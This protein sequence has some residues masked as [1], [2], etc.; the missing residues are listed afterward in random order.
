MN[1]HPTIGRAHREVTLDVVVLGG[2]IAGLWLLAHLRARGYS[3]LLCE[4]EALGRGQTIAA[5]G[6]IHGGT[7]YAIG[8][9]LSKASHELAAM[10]S[11]WLRCLDGDDQPDLS[12]ARVLSPHHYLFTDQRLGTRF[13]AFLASKSLR[14]R[15]TP[16]AEDERPELLA[17]A[18]S[19][20]RGSVY[21]VDE[22]VVDVP[23]V[24]AALRQQH[25]RALL[26]VHADV[27]WLDG[28]DEEITVEVHVDERHGNGGDPCRLRC[29]RVVLTAGVGNEAL[30]RAL[31]GA[32]PGVPPRMQRRPLQMV[33]LRGGDLPA[34]YGHCISAGSDTPRFTLVSFRDAQD[35]PGWYLGG[36]LSDSGAG[37]DAQGQLETA[38]RE[39][40]TVLPWVDLADCQAATLTLDRA[41]GYRAGRRPS[42]PV[43]EH[44]RH[45][46]PVTV[47]WPTKLAFAPRVAELVE[48]RLRDDGVAPSAGSARRDAETLARLD[49]WPRPAVA[50]PPWDVAFG[51]EA[52]R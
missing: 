13:T 19:R 41:E 40:A 3:A 34:F 31:A 52:A 32:G 47:V 6:I 44:L 29:R 43:V 15:V 16:V 30:G 27:R 51:Q 12:A 38:R 50:T 42:G 48:A 21:R 20:F 39:L 1:D 4:S 9:T 5:Q 2:G 24:L 17:R 18:G 26:A 37:R 45:P 28:N 46:G 10:P 14:A 33:L 35:R 8:G 23:S 49:A 11:R 36:A 22:P 25:L 7:K